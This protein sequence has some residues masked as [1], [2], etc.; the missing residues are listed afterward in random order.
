M[1]EQVRGAMDALPIDERKAIELAYF[2]GHSYRDVALDPRRTG[3]H[4]EESHPSWPASSP[5][6]NCTLRASWELT[7]NGAPQITPKWK[8][9]P[10]P[11]ALDALERDEVDVFELHLSECPRCRADVQELRETASLLAHAGA[12]APDGLWDRIASELDEAPD[13]CRPAVAVPIRVGSKHHR[14][15]S[16]QWRMGLVIAA[17]AVVGASSRGEHCRARS[18]RTIE[19]AKLRHCAV[20]RQRAPTRRASPERSHV[21]GGSRSRRPTAPLPPTPW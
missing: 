1:A 7:P 10:A 11:Y 20:H 5:R 6:P 3:G 17:A 4:R 21:A 14:V 16:R 15:T 13:E 12:S 9:W 18:I 2:G 8:S 19:I